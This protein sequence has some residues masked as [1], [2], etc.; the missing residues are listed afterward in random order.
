MCVCR[1]RV[2]E[3]VYVSV[4]TYVCM[5]VCVCVKACIRVIVLLH[6]YVYARVVN[7]TYNVRRTYSVNNTSSLLRE[8][9]R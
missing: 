7:C 1:V 5:C 6:V 4:Y 8:T 9:R 3:G 2:Y